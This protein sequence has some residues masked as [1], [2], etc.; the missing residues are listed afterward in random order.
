MRYIFILLLCCIS[1]PVHAVTTTKYYTTSSAAL[2]ACEAYRPTIEF[3]T[4]CQSGGN[5]AASAKPGFCVAG[6]MYQWVTT[7]G[8][9]TGRFRYCIVGTGGQHCTGGRTWSN[10]AQACQCP[11]GHTWDGTSCIVPP[12]GACPEGQAKELTDTCHPV[13]CN[14]EYQR[15]DEVAKIC[16]GTDIEAP[17]SCGSQTLQVNWIVPPATDSW[18]CVS[19]C[20]SP[21]LMSNDGVC[22][23]SPSTGNVNQAGTTE[24]DKEKAASNQQSAEATQQQIDQ[25]VA[26]KEADKAA[27]AQTAEQAR[28]AYEQIKND[29]NSTQAQIDAA[30][31]NY[32]QALVNANNAAQKKASAE[33][34]QTGA[35][36][37]K[38]V[39]DDA[40]GSIGHAVDPANASVIRQGSDEAYQRMLGR[41]NDAVAGYNTQ[42]PGNGTGGTGTDPSSA[43]GEKTSASGSFPG[44]GEG[45]YQ[46]A[47][48]DGLQ[49]IWNEHKA[50]I[51][52][53]PIMSTL[54]ILNP[55]SSL[56][57]SGSYPIWEMT[58]WMLG[59]FD[60][61]SS[62]FWIFPILRAF[63]L[64]TTLFTIRS[65]IFGG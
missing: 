15:F 41:L 17:P 31:Q 65:I 29:P 63:L 8:T 55:F 3:A 1:L 5:V 33:A 32:A 38:Q 53:S 19:S 24:A 6:D 28:Q 51:T 30:L 40:A 35:Q 49:G 11:S 23:Q 56:G 22:F 64:I 13:T 16:V 4:T 10:D 52:Q 47:Y 59:T 12:S 58:F 50:A 18:S 48:P 62:Y 45:F 34:A 27:T 60:T 9:D 44:V 25:Q 54:G 20:P 37:E 46:S 39:I 61:G 21:S 2:D 14:T 43:A 26:T 7:N 57:N 36:S 42:M